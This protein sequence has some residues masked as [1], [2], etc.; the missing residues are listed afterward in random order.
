MTF[1]F[2]VKNGKSRI[3]KMVKSTCFKKAKATI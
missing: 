3:T 2:E 1:E